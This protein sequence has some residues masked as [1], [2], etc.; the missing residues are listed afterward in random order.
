SNQTIAPSQTAE[1]KQAAAVKPQHD[2]VELTGAALAKSL[3]LAGQTAA[4]IALKM[5][6]DVK[7]VDS[8]LGVK[9]PTTAPT[10]PV[11]TPAASQPKASETAK[12]KK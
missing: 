8:Y 11:P 3:K 7:I 12:G 5:G 10:T 4:Q 9:A 1:P 2:T 6:L